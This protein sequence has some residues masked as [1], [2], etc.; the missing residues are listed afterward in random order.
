MSVI[1]GMII[2]CLVSALSVAT[3]VDPAAGRAVVAGMAGPLV[4]ACGTWMM[5]DRTLQANPGE[6]MSRLLVAFLVKVVLYLAYVFVAVKI[7][8]MPVTPFALS[9]TAYFIVLQQTE[10]LLLRR[11][12]ARAFHA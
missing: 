6:M 9:F 8:G 12:T 4:S 5:I 10:A 7:L 1:G 3:V 11:R 2:A